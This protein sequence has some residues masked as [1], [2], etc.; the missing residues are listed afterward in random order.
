MILSFYMLP[1]HL[2]TQL[3]SPGMNVC[4]IMNSKGGKSFIIY[5]MYSTRINKKK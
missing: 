3:I 5:V 1:F 2:I 4:Q